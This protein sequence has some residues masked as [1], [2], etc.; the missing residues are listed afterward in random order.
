VRR[1]LTSIFVVVILAAGLAAC[2]GTGAYNTGVQAV[3]ATV[4]EW[5]Q[6]LSAAGVNLEAALHEVTG[7]GRP[8]AVLL[9]FG[10]G[11]KFLVTQAGYQREQAAPANPTAQRHVHDGL[12]RD[13]GCEH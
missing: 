5:G 6:C 4:N 13:P 11:D 7:T 1:L 2:G 9:T 10:S 12:R 8:D 3:S